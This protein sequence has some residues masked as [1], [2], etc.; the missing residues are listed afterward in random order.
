M[1]EVGDGRDRFRYGWKK[2]VKISS[3]LPPALFLRRGLI[4]ATL[5][6]KN[7]IHLIVTYLRQ[8]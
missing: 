8:N 3:L 2:Q 7:F 1:T 6:N 4:Y 5:A